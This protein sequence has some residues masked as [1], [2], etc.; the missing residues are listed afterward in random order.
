[1]SARRK[2]GPRVSP[3]RWRSRFVLLG[4]GLCAA[5]LEARVLYLQFVN[6]DFLEAQGD[7]RHLRTV[8]IVAHRGAITDRHGEPLAV[9]APVDSIWANPKELRRELDRLGELAAKLGVPERELAEK[10]ASN[11]DREFVY[12]KRHMPPAQAA[13]VMALGIP[14]VRTLREYRRFYPPAEVV[15]HVVGFTDIDDNGLEGLELAYN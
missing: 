15:G 13:E 5:A 9:S 4:L 7:S 8:Q 12:L 10:I 14:G 3:P 6:Q 2:N 11:L 1:M